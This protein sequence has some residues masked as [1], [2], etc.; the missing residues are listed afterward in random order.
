M[1]STNRGAKRNDRDFY[2]TPATAVQALL[3][4]I[5]TELAHLGRFWL[6]PAVGDGA[7]LRAVRDH[8]TRSYP[9]PLWDTGDIHPLEDPKFFIENERAGF[10]DFTRGDFLKRE[11]R[12][13]YDVIITNPPFSLAQEFIEHALYLCPNKDPLVI[14]LL[15]LGILESKKRSAWW[16]DKHPDAVAVLS[17]RPDFTG[18]GG[19]SC[20]YGWF[21]W[22][23]PPP[24][25][26]VFVLPP[27]LPG[28]SPCP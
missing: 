19:D 25:C 4:M 3:N 13:D 8:E 12:I 6:E 20:A 11:T 5:D 15:R 24:L 22:N 14:M 10:C 1:S 21:M 23:C 27:C 28:G 26:G 16:Q 7:I 18:E 9:T 17:E 2:A